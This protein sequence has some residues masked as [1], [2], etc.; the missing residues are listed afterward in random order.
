MSQVVTP[1]TYFDDL[2]REVWR[3]CVTMEPEGDRHRLLADVFKRVSRESLE[4]GLRMLKACTVGDLKKD[5]FTGVAVPET[6]EQAHVRKVETQLIAKVEAQF[7]TALAA[8][9]A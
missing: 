2:A 8:V 6:A 3:E 5:P 1:N 7:K 4:D 9:G